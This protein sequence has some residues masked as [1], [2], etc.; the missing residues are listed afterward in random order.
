MTQFNCHND[1]LTKIKASLNFDSINRIK[2]FLPVR[3]TTLETLCRRVIKDTGEGG[4]L[5]KYTDDPILRSNIQEIVIKITQQIYVINSLRSSTLLERKR[6]LVLKIVNKPHIARNK[7]YMCK[8]DLFDYSGLY[9][10]KYAEKKYL[11]NVIFDHTDYAQKKHWRL[12]LMKL[13]GT[14][15]WFELF[16]TL[17]QYTMGEY[18]NFFEIQ[19][20]FSTPKLDHDIFMLFMSR[21]WQEKLEKIKFFNQIQNLPIHEF[22][23]WQM[24][25]KLSGDVES[26]PG[27]S[28]LSRFMRNNNSSIKFKQHKAQMFSTT[29]KNISSLTSFLENQLPNLTNQLGQI[30]SNMNI[31]VDNSILLAQSKIKE[32]LN[33]LVDQ[34]ESVLYKIEAMQSKLLK[35]LLCCALIVIMLSLKW[36]KA[37]LVT[38]CIGLLSLFGIPQTIINMFK[39]CF[40]KQEAQVFHA[41]P[42]TLGPLLGVIICFFMIG[43]LPKDSAI[44]NFSKKTAN[45]SRGLSGMMRMNDD[46]SKLWNNIQGFVTEQLTP[47]L[48]E[49]FKTI[50]DEIGIWTESIMK[51]TDMVVRKKA[52]ID[53]EKVVE[54]AA[55]LKEG[56][57]LKKW[58]FQNKADTKMCQHIANIC[59]HAEQLY[60]YTDTN[61]SLGGGQRQRPLS[62]VLFGESQIGK[63]C[64]IY[65]LCQDLLFAAGYRKASDLQQQVY[66]RLTENEFWDGY[67]N[68]MIAINDDALAKVD[69]E[70]NPNKEIEEQIRMSNDFPFPVHMAAIEDKN[71]FFTSK[72]SI[73]TVNN[74]KTPI[75]S[76]TYPEAF[77]NRITANMYEVMP[78]EEFAIHEEM[79][80]GIFRTTLDMDKV[81]KHLD[82]LSAEKGYRVPLSLDVYVFYKYKQ[83]HENGKVNF[84]VDKE[85]K[86]L[87]YKEFSKLMCS[88]L[89]S[90]QNSFQVK[91]T[92][93]DKRLEEKM[94]ELQNLKDNIPSGSKSQQ[95]QVC[96]DDEEIQFFDCS[97]NFCDLITEEIM[98]GKSMEEIDAL[99]LEKHGDAYV[100]FKSESN[101]YHNKPIL[102][103]KYLTEN[104]FS[105]LKSSCK[106][107][108]NKLKQYSLDILNKY[109]MLKY[110]FTIGTVAAGMYAI[111]LL[112]K[113]NNKTIEHFVMNDEITEEEYQQNVSWIQQQKF[114]SNE[115]MEYWK[116]NLM[117]RHPEEKAN[118]IAN[119]SAESLEI[120][121]MKKFIS[122]SISSPGQGTTKHL[123]KQK[124]ESISSPGQGTTKQ[125]KKQHVEIKEHDSEGT[126]DVN[127]LELAFSIM[128]NNLYSMSYMVDGKP[129]LLG[130][131]I[132]IKGYNILFPHHFITYLKHKQCS[133]D[134]QLVL[135]RVNYK[136]EHFN[137]SV[138]F[139]LSDLVNKDWTLNRAIKLKNVDETELDAVIFCPSESSTMIN[140]KNLI[141]HF[142]DKSE[143]GRLRGKMTGFIL[144]YR[145]DNGKVAKVVKSLIDVQPYDKPI[146]ISIGDDEFLQRD[147][148][149]YNGDTE[150][151][152][153]GGP[154]VIKSNSLIR[155]L[156]GMHISG[157]PDEGFSVKLTSN[158]L[159]E[160]ITNLVLKLGTLSHRA[161]CYL[162]ISDKILVNENCETPSGV[163]QELGKVKY[164]LGQCSKSVLKPSL[165]QNEITKIT[166]IPAKLHAFVNSNNQLIDPA[167]KGL[168]KCGG[169]SLLVDKKICHMAENYIAQKI[170]KD[171]RRIGYMNYARVMTYEEAIKGNDDQ[172]ISAMCRSTSPGYPFNSDPK[173][174][175]NLPGKQAWMG[176]NEN[177]DF[178]SIKAL[179]LRKIVDE[180]KENCLKGKICDVICADTMKDERRPI[181]KVNEGKTR[182][183][184]ACPMHYVVLFRQYFVGYAAFLMHNRNAN[185]IAVGTNVYSTDWDQI[186]REISKK[187][188]K[189]LAGDFSNFDGSL[190]SQVLWSVYNIIEEFYKQYDNNY[191]LDDRNIRYSLWVHLVNSIHVHKD[192]LYQWTHSQPSGNPFTVIINSIYNQLV[193]VIGYLIV[194]RDSDLEPLDKNSLMNTMSFDK[195]VSMVVYGDD[196]LLNI[197][198]DISDLF[199]QQTLTIALKSIGHDYTEENKDKEIHKFRTINE[200]SFLKRKFTWDRDE[201]KWLAPLDIGVIYEMLNWVRG[202]SVDSKDLLKSNIETAVMEMSL[203]SMEK[204][205]TFIQQLKANNK[206]KYII[207]PTYPTFGEARIKMSNS[208]SY[209]GFMA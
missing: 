11:E 163:F 26:N 94:A 101:N 120:P 33:L 27:P 151:G 152:D 2:D 155:K 6:P 85:H 126:S 58:A 115:M 86:P 81:E 167:L 149:L 180:L 108:F 31:S 144:S 68:Q 70:A 28:C 145:N 93:F 135:T 8:Y 63:S 181:A 202:N 185:G 112:F 100:E 128:K 141:K 97:V 110:L 142:I 125:L 79:G 66:A 78:A 134:T 80:G 1:T 119:T 46:V 49:D 34:S 175:T 111:Y 123:K 124:V 98:A 57:R 147:G 200:V 183:F 168:E 198:S 88:K 109:P 153:C 83:I 203:H 32:D 25:L 41:N 45:I 51:Y 164:A 37:A 30:I 42:S 95:A 82:N 166:T 62:I 84:I 67:K 87:N 133:G 29:Q 156:V 189:V 24:Q 170:N 172:Y 40:N 47:N 157:A 165:I 9:G 74:I 4:L 121:I 53:N 148:Y 191:T 127:A 96:S 77:Y 179:E 106:T 99:L 69:T 20:R 50:E 118:I 44:E 169:V 158:M 92:F 132:A 107:Y 38:G 117:M 14:E 194:I 204:F 140:H 195:H 161:N 10:Q 201:S 150:Q 35:T 12:K 137:A 113:D 186:V 19:Y 205:D 114:E 190:L 55:L 116:I 22:H 207:Q 13:E 162:E 129:K 3:M 59:R 75:K 131:V 61:N 122:E 192:N 130:N 54:I 73:M 139:L 177:F 18:D 72:V 89:L 187:G 105:D 76:L 5:R 21:E 176:S 71:T 16:N 7:K 208:S 56:I 178:T 143:L 206:L 188:P 102:K 15:F 23:T 104:L 154:L 64:M 138:T 103:F 17:L 36:R 48:P 171:Y 196:N 159:E 184:S 160:G 193:M 199:N 173:F 43:K 209:E 39:D 182:M 197:S 65:P 52:M 90:N 60:K 146:K 136:D 174:K 91:T